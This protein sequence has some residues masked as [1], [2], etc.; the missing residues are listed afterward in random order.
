MGFADRLKE[1]MKRKGVGVAEFAGQVPVE[2]NS[3]SRWRAGY[4]PGPVHL[5]RVAALLDVSTGYLKEGAGEQP[6][7][8]PAGMTLGSQTPVSPSG[9][10]QDQSLP[11]H[12]PVSTQATDR[13]DGIPPLVEPLIPDSAAEWTATIVVYKA[14]LSYLDDLTRSGSPAN[15]KDIYFFFNRLAVASQQDSARAKCVPSKPNGEKH[16]G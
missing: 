6:I 14:A 8:F 11:Y 9:E 13:P 4:V 7:E 2:P 16:A 3:V 10:G 15:P 1:A 12:P 5:A